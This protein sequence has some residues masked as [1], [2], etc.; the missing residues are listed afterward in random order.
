M[1]GRR[2]VRERHDET[3]QGRCVEYRLGNQK[4]SSRLNLFACPADFPL[5][6]NCIGVC[7]DSDQRLCDGVNRLA[8]EVDT[9]V[10]AALNPCHA[11]G[12]HIE[13]AGR[14]RVVAELRR[15]AVM[16]RML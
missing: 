2:K 11:D 5:H 14:E 8:A 10:Q 7:A 3:E 12:V 1:T 15:V 6:V 9:A 13:Y 16:N 4:L